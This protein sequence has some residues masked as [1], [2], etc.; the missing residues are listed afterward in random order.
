MKH[1]APAPQ[2][3][4][5]QEADEGAAP[6]GEGALR[7]AAPAL[8]KGLDIL[9]ALADSVSGYTLNE[10]A[11]KVGR[12]VSEI[13]RMAVTLQRR[14][15][16][17]VDENDRYTLT[18]RMF[19]LA[20]RQ[21]P[22]KSLVSV[23]LPLLRELANRARQSCHLAMYQGGR[24]VVIAQVESPERWSFGLKVGVVMGLTD[25]SSGHVLLAF[26]D[27]IDRAR[28]LRAHIGVE[29]EL[30]MDPG[31]LFA[32]L[33]DVRERG[34]SAM[35][36]KQTRGITNIAF[37]VMGAADHVI[38]SINVP[39]IERI[40]QKSAPDAVQVRGIVGNIAGRLSA[41]MGA[42]GYNDNE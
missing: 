38:A 40:D 19:E 10:L 9:E 15:F 4:Q 34:Y 27:E 35:P 6:E 36:S 42:S 18:L 39:Y 33:Q 11:Q 16:V 25:T 26:R 20:H 30:E 21:Q 32:M 28:M 14:G 5:G 1:A 24:V 23:A 31:E 3:Q 12:K 37:P 2:E 41:L 22:L 17:Q 13:F 29:G 7:Y 8:E